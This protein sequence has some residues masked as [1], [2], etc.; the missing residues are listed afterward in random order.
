M[1]DLDRY[2]PEIAA[3]DAEVFGLWVAGVESELRAS[4]RPFAATVDTESVVQETL[5]RIWQ[6]APRHVP[7]GKPQSL[8]RLAV[9]IAR[10]LAMDEVRRVRAQPVDPGIPDA[11]DPD[12]PPSDPFLRRVI[13]ECYRRLGGKP[14][15]ALAA[16]LASGGAAPDEVIAARLGMRLNTFLQN[17]TRARRQLAECLRAR[18]IDIDGA[19]A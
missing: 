12:P 5:L 14:A 19:Q 11:G 7:D 3:G 9:R 13:V 10:N 16:R 2:L 4:L 17:F 18:G 8:L 15:A 6:V 1:A